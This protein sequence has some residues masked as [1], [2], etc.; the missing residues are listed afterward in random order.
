MKYGAEIWKHALRHIENA[1][2]ITIDMT[3]VKSYDVV[4]TCWWG[5]LALPSPSLRVGGG[6]IPV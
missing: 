5:N 2:I 1:K 4:L 3:I 6:A